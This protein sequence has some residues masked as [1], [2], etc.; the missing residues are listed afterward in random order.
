MSRLQ[1]PPS[2]AATIPGRMRNFTNPAT[3]CTCPTPDKHD[4]YSPL[5][6]NLSYN[7]YVTLYYKNNIKGNDN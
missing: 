5:F 4:P 3:P 6:L 1:R 7:C 2:E